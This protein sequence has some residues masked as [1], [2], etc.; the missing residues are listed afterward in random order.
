MNFRMASPAIIVDLG[1]IPN[2]AYMR[3]SGGG[4]HIGAMTRQRSVEFSPLIGEKLLLLR[5]AIK[6]VG[7]LPTRSRGTIGGSIAHADPSAEIPLVLQA[8]E[9]DVVARVPQ[10]ARPIKAADFFR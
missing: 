10:G 1:R 7:H 3:E 9:G 4:I 5:D 6:W 2:L 8:L